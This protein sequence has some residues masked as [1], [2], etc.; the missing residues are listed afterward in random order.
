MSPKRL[1]ID[2]VVSP[3]FQENT[4]IVRAADAGECVVIDPGFTPREV[5]RHIDQAGLT[6]HAILLTH[7]HVDHIAGNAD[8]RVRWPEL[9]ILIGEKDAVMLIDP[10]ANLSQKSG[11]AIVSPPADQLLHEGDCL[12][13]AGLTFQVLDIPGHSPGHVAFVWSHGSETH[14]FGGDVLFQGSIGR[15]DLPGG[16]MRQLIDGIRKKLFCLPDETVVYPGH[17]DPTTVGEERQTNPYC[18]LR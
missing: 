14:V 8:L 10:V 1:Q 17:G 12:Q 4:W 6:P 3:P 11:M 7:G 18:A 2:V 16:N 9:P 5:I 13:I 15:C